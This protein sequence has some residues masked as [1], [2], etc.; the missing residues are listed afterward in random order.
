[1]VPYFPQ[2]VVHLGPLQIHAFGVL[3]AIAVIVGGRSILMRAHRKNIPAEEMFR[4]CFWVY[5]AAML[6]AYLSKGI[7]DDFPAVLSDPARI[8]RVPQG[9][10]SVG[11]ITAGFLA[12][13]VW[14][15]IRG[16]SLF[17]SMRRMDIIAY[18]LPIAWMIGRLG[19]ALAHDHK[20]FSSTSWLAVNFPE[21]PR[22]DLGLIEFLFLAGMVIAFRWLDRRPRSPGFFFGLYGV[23][24]GAFRIWLDTLHMQPMRFYGGIA[25]VAA[26]LAGWAVMWW[27]ERSRSSALGIT[28]DGR[29]AH[30]LVCS[31][32][33]H[34]DALTTSSARDS[35]FS[36]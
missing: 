33:T 3:A 28:L 24:Y 7:I 15:R 26:G 20:G 36:A 25:G 23:V 13:V 27:L 2:P 31:V 16:L 14:C 10:R 34:A 12:A 29:G 4:L 30:A 32:G 5:I 8:L 22:W 6:G 19:C 35:N 9:V 11:G 18:S 21:G 1:M 17:Q